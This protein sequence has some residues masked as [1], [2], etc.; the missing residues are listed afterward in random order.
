M[1]ELHIGYVVAS[2]GRVLVQGQHPESRTGFA[3]Y[4][5]EQC[6][7]DG[8]ESGEL[9]WEAVADDDPRVTPADRD[10]LGWVLQTLRLASQMDE[11]FMINEA[12]V[13]RARAAL[14]A[15][16]E[17]DLTPDG[18]KPLHCRDMRYWCLVH[19]CGACNGWNVALGATEL[20][21]AAYR[22]GLAYLAYDRD[23]GG[24]EQIILSGCAS[25]E[26]V[27][28]F[29]DNWAPAHGLV[30]AYGY[31]ERGFAGAYCPTELTA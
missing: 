8:F 4:D 24:R 28:A 10:R 5:E 23:G 3:L 18:P 25:P 30:D 2:S 22:E 15:A 19:D 29:V 13:E 16:P 21:E 27:R 7:P 17:I 14:L 11:D 12:A 20:L 26:M 6:W 31:S 1:A 9:D